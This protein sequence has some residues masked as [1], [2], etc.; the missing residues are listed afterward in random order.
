M[1]PELEHF[2]FLQQFL[3]CVGL[4]IAPKKKHLFW[5]DP[6]NSLVLLDCTSNW[7][8]FLT[9]S[10]PK[11]NCLLTHSAYA[12]TELNASTDDLLCAGHTCFR[13]PSSFF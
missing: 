4:K 11:K 8:R 5:L 7:L 2:L 12:T 1:R 10:V 6:P 13:Q 9:P 3:G